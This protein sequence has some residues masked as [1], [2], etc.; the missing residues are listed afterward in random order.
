MDHSSLISLSNQSQTV[1]NEA[2]LRLQLTPTVQALLA[3]QA[4]QEVMALPAQRLTPI[5]NMPAHVLGLMNRR[6]RVLWV[7]NLA[8]LL[9]MPGF[10]VDRRQ[11]DLVLL[12]VDSVALAF[13]VHQVDSLCWLPPDQIQPPPLQ[14]PVLL[15]SYLRGCVVRN[16]ETWFVLDPTRLAAICAPSDQAPASALSPA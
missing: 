7:M 15:Q 16:Q 11:Y 3:M 13:V 6:S 2:Y 4:V 5:P 1:L 8:H 12:Q 10:K 14:V 9:E